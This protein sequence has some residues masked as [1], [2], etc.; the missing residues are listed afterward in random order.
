MPGKRRLQRIR[1][2]QPARRQQLEKN[3]VV[4]CE[5]DSPAGAHGL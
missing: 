3:T 2:D 5:H 4:P 1:R